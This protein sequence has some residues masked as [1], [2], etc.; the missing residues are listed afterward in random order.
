MATDK[1]QQQQIQI[2]KKIDNTVENI[3]FPKFK[4]ILQKSVDL[5]YYNLYQPIYYKRKYR[6]KNQWVL[7][8]NNGKYEFYIDESVGFNH[9]G[10]NYYL[11]EVATKGGIKR[12]VNGQI[13]YTP[14]PFISQLRNELKTNVIFKNLLKEYGLTMIENNNKK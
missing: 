6:F 4:E 8:K 3:I 12:L 10:K 13:T 7:K 11:P 2:Q 14:R 1:L 9:K 5:N